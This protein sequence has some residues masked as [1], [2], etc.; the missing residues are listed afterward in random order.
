MAEIRTGTSF[1]AIC[2]EK[3]LTSLGGGRGM[4]LRL[5]LGR[6]VLYRKK[7]L[8]IF[9]FRFRSISIRLYLPVEPMRNGSPRLNRSRIM[10]G[11]PLSERRP[12]R[13]TFESRKTLTTF[14]RISLL[15]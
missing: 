15:I 12:E 9:F 1:S 14:F 11:A 2:Q 3:F 10:R 13:I 5:S 6:Y 4:T 8:G 7:R